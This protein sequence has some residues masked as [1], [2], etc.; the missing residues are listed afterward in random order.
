MKR[1]YKLQNT[2]YK[3]ITNYKL[4]TRHAC[5]KKGQVLNH[6][7][8][9]YKQKTSSSLLRAK[10]QELRANLKMEFNDE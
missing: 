1:N 9:N 3:Q 6:N 4:Q 7:V 8:R 10:S 5:L 2:N